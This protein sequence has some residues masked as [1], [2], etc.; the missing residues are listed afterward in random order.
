MGKLIKCVCTS[1]MFQCGSFNIT[2]ARRCWWW[3]TQQR[4]QIAFGMESDA[5]GKE[6][7]ISVCFCSYFYDTYILWLFLIRP[8]RCARK[9]GFGNKFRIEPKCRNNQT[10]KSLTWIC[11]YEARGRATGRCCWHCAL[12]TA[13]MNAV[14]HSKFIYMDRWL[15]R[16]LLNISLEE[17]A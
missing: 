5:C 6:N 16:K 8:K 4:K 15:E 10:K 17:N 12:A 11:I 2:C 9:F 14:P 7:M 13:S 3:R 1:V